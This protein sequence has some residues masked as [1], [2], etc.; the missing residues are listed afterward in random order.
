MTAGT[1]TVPRWRC[2]RRPDRAARQHAGLTRDE[3]SAKVNYSSSL[4]G[5]I[6]TGRRVP[7]V[8]W[9]NGSMKSS[10]RT[11]ARSPGWRPACGTCPTGLVPPSSAHQGRRTRSL[12]LFERILVPG[13]LQTA[14]CAG[15]LVHTA[16]HQRD[17][18][19]ELVTARLARQALLARADPPLLY[20]LLDE[21]VLHRPVATPE[22]MAV[23]L[24]RLAELSERPTS[25]SRSSCTARVRTSACRAGSPSQTCPIC[26][27]S[28]FWIR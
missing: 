13:L 24:A 10:A 25:R 15:G 3:L 6:E 26:P 19:E 23:Q 8:I 17:E 21:G 20:V 2:C 5:M 11:G 14:D 1:T 22:I 7:S 12:R 27:V 9:P 16:A 4:I 28:C 18:V